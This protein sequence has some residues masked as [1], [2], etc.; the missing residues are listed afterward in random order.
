MDID[1]TASSNVEAVSSLHE[2]DTNVTK[3]EKITYKELM[4][5]ANQSIALPHNS[6]VHLL[7]G[8][9]EL[10]P[11]DV[12]DLEAN[13]D[14]ADSDPVLVWTAIR[15]WAASNISC[16]DFLCDKAKWA[17]R[18][19]LSTKQRKHSLESQTY[20]LQVH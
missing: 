20:K 8:K 17:E 16:W 19:P 11:A 14:I 9:E 3:A 6:V 7:D 15:P 18:P 1:A 4:M 10:D 12:N 2:D 5:M 13:E